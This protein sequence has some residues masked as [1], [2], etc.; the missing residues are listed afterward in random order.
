MKGDHLEHLPHFLILDWHT[1]HGD[2]HPP[3][4]D[5]ALDAMCV[6]CL[7]YRRVSTRT[8]RWVARLKRPSTHHVLSAAPEG[9][10]GLTT[11]VYIFKGRLQLACQ[12]NRLLSIYN[13]CARVRLHVDWE[14]ES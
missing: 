14:R 7:M 13:V 5:A 9:S 8:L 2:A 6:A 10:L 12:F 3:A 11:L 1:C 4:L